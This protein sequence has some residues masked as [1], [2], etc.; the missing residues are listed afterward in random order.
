MNPS[1]L[2][3][4]YLVEGRRSDGWVVISRHHR[5]DQAVSSW[6]RGNGKRRIRV[7]LPRQRLDYDAHRDAMRLGLWS[8]DYA[9][10]LRQS[11]EDR[12]AMECKIKELKG[13]ER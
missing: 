3:T 7:L 8:D 11:D 5:Y 4:R 9:A 12:Q 13:T 6:E 2:T 10:W 1:R